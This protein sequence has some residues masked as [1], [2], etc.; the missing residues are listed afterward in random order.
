MVMYFMHFFFAVKLKIYLFSFKALV[1][2]DFK[3]VICIIQ[4]CCQMAFKT[5]KN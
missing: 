1:G 3:C 4:I 5:E 2:Y